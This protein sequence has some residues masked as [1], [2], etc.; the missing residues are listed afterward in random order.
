MRHRLTGAILLLYQRRVREGHGPEIVALIDDLIAH[1]GRSR[2]GLVIRLAV[3]GLVQ[4]VAS[5]ATVWTMV[6]VLATTSLG[7]L[8]VS[9]FAAASALQGVR[10]TLHTVAPALHSLGFER[11]RQAKRSSARCRCS[12][13]RTARRSRSRQPAQ[14]RWPPSSGYMVAASR[15]QGWAAVLPRAQRLVAS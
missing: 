8:A 7:G 9:N 5:T 14:G 1:E 6:V 11:A 15:N 13:Y 3:D 2:T 10:G 4:R 12:A